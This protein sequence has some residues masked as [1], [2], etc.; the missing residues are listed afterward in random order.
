MKKALSILTIVLIIVGICAIGV[1]ATRDNKNEKELVASARLSREGSSTEEARTSNLNFY[2]NLS[3][4]QDINALIIGDSIGQ[5]NG[6]SNDDKK[7]SNL[8]AKDVKQKYKSTMTTDFITG[9]STT[10]V[11]AWVELNN[12][13]PTKKYDI[14]FICFGQKDQWNIKPE[15]FGLFYES[16]IIKLKKTN[17]NIEIIPIIESS[18]REDNA[19]S[20][21]IKDLS[22]NYNLQYADTI[23]G[24]ASSGEIYEKLTTDIEI[25]NDK[26][27]SQY[28]TTIE[29]VI[30]DNYKA[31]KK[32]NSKYNAF[33]KDTSKLNKF[34]FDDSP[35]FKIGF[36]LESGM[37][38]NKNSDTLTFNTTS[39][40]A[41]IH[42]LR[43]PSGGKFKVFIDDKFKCEVDTKSKVEVSYSN[44]ISDDLEG[45]HKIK[46]EISSMNKGE[47]VKI[48]GL[49]TN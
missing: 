30:E 40:V 8:I 12:S 5:S 11:R 33:Y 20:S 16:I 22:K 14:A 3:E 38:S 28:A 37:I 35:D 42:F 7:W 6:S 31:K 26:G 32:T 45:P 24:F 19:Y 29:K 48:L 44:L 47:T 15:Q 46:I 34:I 43:K 4:S 27:Y 23:K 9:D 10:G 18:F 17:P 36:E 2:E 41:I 13:K 21:V 39:S 25:P 49:A 1:G